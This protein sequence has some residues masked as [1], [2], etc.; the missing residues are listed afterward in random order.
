MGVEQVFGTILRSSFRTPIFL[1]SFFCTPFFCLFFLPFHTNYLDLPI[2]CPHSASRR[3][4][5][6]DMTSLRSSQCSI[7]I[8]EYEIDEQACLGR[9]PGSEPQL[10]QKPVAG[11]P[12]G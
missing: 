2:P 4:A 1:D 6:V 9:A 12:W 11:A 7:C 5:Q 10:S 8:S 3:L